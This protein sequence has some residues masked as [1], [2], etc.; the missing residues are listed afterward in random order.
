MNTIDITILPEQ[1]NF[2]IIRAA[3]FLLYNK[4]FQYGLFRCQY[5]QKKRFYKQKGKEEEETNNKYARN[6][7][8]K[9]K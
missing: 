7:A 6:F 9:K 1:T 4:L 3:L 8:G 2:I 5:K